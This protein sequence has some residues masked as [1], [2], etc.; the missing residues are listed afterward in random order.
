M[1]LLPGKVPPPAGARLKLLGSSELTPAPPCVEDA[2][3]L[4]ERARGSAA[5]AAV[6]APTPNNDFCEVCQSAGRLLL[7][8][9]CPRAFHGRC[10]DRLV[11]LDSLV[12][13]S[14]WACPVCCHGADV[15][16]GRPRS[17]LSITEMQAHMAQARKRTK[18][19]RREAI[20]RRDLFLS[21]HLALISPFATKDAIRR[22]ERLAQATAA[23]IEI[24]DL[25][26]AISPQGRRFEA[27]VLAQTSE[28]RYL[29]ADAA[30]RD[31]HEIDRDCIVPVL[32]ARVGAAAVPDDSGGVG[33]DLTAGHVTDFIAHSPSALLADG[34]VLKDY[35][36]AGVNWLVRAI[37]NRCGAVLADDMGLGKTLQTLALLSYLRASGSV[38]GPF[39]VVVPLSC[40]GNWI[41]EAKRFVPHLSISKVCGGAKER[42]YCLSDDELRFAVKDIVVTTYE[43]LVASSEFFIDHSWAVLV[44][45]EAHRIK[46]S[47]GMAREVLDHID[48]ASRLLLT[49]T[50][51]QNNMGELFSLL[52]FLWPDVLVRDSDV[53][54]QS[55]QFADVKMA[56]AAASNPT[57]AEA[58]AE[59]D[60]KV[61]V[62]T[63]GK[64]RS[65]L[66]MLMLRR[67]KENVVDLPPKVFHNVWLPLSPCQ[68]T[69]YRQLLCIRTIVQRKGLR[70]LLKLVVRLRLLSGHPRCV[71]AAKAD[72]VDL[73]QHEA[74]DVGE[75][76]K[77]ASEPRM[78]EEIIAQSGKLAFLDK[79][80]GQ[81]H[82]Q[83]MGVS[84]QWLKAYEERQR[85][86]SHEKQKGPRKS[87]A[88]WLR[89]TDSLLFLEEMSPWKKLVVAPPHDAE[90]S[91]RSSENTAQVDIEL[92]ASASEATSAL[93][94]APKPHKVLIFSQFHATLDILEAWCAF[95]GW[96]HFRLDG[97][98]S[99]VLRELDMRDFNAGEEDY[100]VYLIGT[101]AGGLGI[102]LA[103]ANHVVLFEQDWNPH[104]DSQAIDRAHRIGQNRQVNVYK[105]MQ[106]WGVEERLVH[107][108]EQKLEME[109]CVISG[110]AAGEDEAAPAVRE[111]LSGEEVIAM[112]RH[113]EAVLK[114]FAGEALE[115]WSIEALLRRGHQPLPAVEAGHRGA[116]S[117]EAEAEAEALDATLGEAFVEDEGD[118]ASQEPAAL[119]V[120]V[121][122][123]QE[124]APPPP[125]P[126]A[127]PAVE[128]GVKRSSRGR[129]LRPPKTSEVPDILVRK[130]VVKKDPMKHETCCFACGK[131][132]RNARRGAK[133]LFGGEEPAAD[134]FCSTCPRGYHTSCMASVAP[135]AAQQRARWN[136]SWHNCAHCAR[137][138]NA[139]GGMLI[140]C[141]QCPSALCYDCFPPSFRRVYAPDQFWSD[142]QTRG[143]KTTPQKMAFFE[144]NSCRALAE[145]ARRQKMRAEELEA[146][147]DDRK[148]AALEE[149]TSLKAKKLRI[150]AEDAQRRTRDFIMQ[151]K[152]A[153]VLLEQYRQKEELQQERVSLQQEQQRLK[154]ELLDAAERLWP[155]GFRARYLASGTGANAKTPIVACTNCHFPG[156]LHHECPFPMEKIRPEDTE[157]SGGK[158]VAKYTRVCT[159]CSK[160][161]HSRLMCPQLAL[162]Q[163][164]EYDARNAS[165]QRLVDAIG[166]AKPVEEPPD[167]SSVAEGKRLVMLNIRYHVEEAL[168]TCDLAHCISASQQLPPAPEA[169]NTAAAKLA[170]PVA[171]ATGRARGGGRG[172]GKGKRGRG[173]LAADAAAA[174]A[175]AAAAGAV[176]AGG[177]DG[178]KLKIEAALGGPLREERSLLD[179]VAAGWTVSCT[180][181]ADGQLFQKFRA[182]H[183]TTWSL[184]QQV[185]TEVEAAAFEALCQEMEDVESVVRRR[186]AATPAEAFTRAPAAPTAGVEGGKGGAR[187]CAERCPHE[188]PAAGWHIKG[189]LNSQNTVYFTFKPLGNQ[190]WIYGNKAKEGVTANI[191]KQVEDEKKSIVAQIRAQQHEAPGSAGDHVDANKIQ[192]DEEELEERENGDQHAGENATVQPSGRRPISTSDHEMRQIVSGPAQNWVVRRVVLASNGQPR[193]TFRRPTGVKWETLPEV[194]KS[195]DPFV[196]AALVAEKAAF[197]APR[198]GQH[199]RASG[200]K[201]PRDEA[202]P[203]QGGQCIEVG[204]E[205]RTDAEETCEP[206]LIEAIDVGTSSPEH[207]GGGD[208]VVA[209]LLTGASLRESGVD[210]PATADAQRTCK[211]DTA[212][213]SP[214]PAEEVALTGGYQLRIRPRRLQVV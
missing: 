44:L 83:N 177:A 129:I 163:R 100:F 134:L 120:E 127:P 5:G 148:R 39:L 65:L 104:V 128:D 142:M 199:Q 67:L 118:E 192:E 180:L 75:L 203:L 161:A 214:K 71:A 11:D 156:H 147:Q 197:T 82:A 8:D 29:I 110:D 145:Q 103:T 179:G 182:P 49:G 154:Q 26:Q 24:G 185:V 101:R 47:A 6:Q 33:I 40:A 201:R 170:E 175:A 116:S 119:A 21:L 60:M 25:V 81:L 204:E 112:L 164:G 131:G 68:A 42:E 80:L 113:G 136:C 166:V 159:V 160:V 190:K 72:R 188:G 70:A 51:L 200:R 35:Q 202:T 63:V 20:R 151:H 94:D 28:K 205:A 157:A 133:E 15:L 77:L 59:P 135:Q 3:M 153:T 18:A 187:Y 92:S 99:R 125:L 210:E 102:N 32:Q 174:A 181:H 124:S 168:R 54:E 212:L 58:M 176:E 178:S 55:V 121:A 88:S 36:A 96:R 31:E 2:P 38:T 34:V 137:S 13:G 144:C 23:L 191:W 16:R 114:K 17:K 150:E 149:R 206:I 10:I 1:R 50:P 89:S 146:Q 90:A 141:L 196:S 195:I 139:C 106:E 143:W 173:R 66:Q 84:A 52:R 207:G 198:L 78:S 171:S 123:A 57:G 111:R 130:V 22:I 209:V 91:A 158:A 87:A 167:G 69:W 48:C 98:T 213:G 19:Q 105:L 155:A 86:M 74:V 9:R 165:L 64:I 132:P 30:T 186:S 172:K 37:H 45:D 46:S 43:T 109:Q 169:A 4:E 27:R 93:A 193:W 162:E 211:L 108:A 41:R 126:P 12:H 138:A 184:R 183:G 140:H 14:E 152:K 76:E 85:W 189:T 107:R 61:D 97:G 194:Q 73:A 115:G 95:R 117:A 56:A 79:L 208:A 62:A 53:F 7:C 122:E